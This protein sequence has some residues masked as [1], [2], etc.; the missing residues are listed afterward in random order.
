MARVQRVLG[1]VQAVPL[2]VVDNQRQR[3]RGAP[4]FWR[5]NA[6]LGG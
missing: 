1:P 6:R 5:Y 4:F 2:V 3:T